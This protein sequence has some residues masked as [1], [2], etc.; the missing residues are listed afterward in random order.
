MEND[1][2]EVV[3]LLCDGLFTWSLNYYSML[4]GATFE[5]IKNCALQHN[6]IA[7]LARKTTFY[8]EYAPYETELFRICNIDQ[9]QPR[10]MP[11]SILN[12]TINID[13]MS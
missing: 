9:Q 2:S 7:N 8:V 13:G 6:Q 10:C 11:S 3:L 5:S 12:E 4:A 1:Q